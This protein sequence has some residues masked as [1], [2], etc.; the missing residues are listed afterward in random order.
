MSSGALTVTVRSGK[1]CGPMLPKGIASVRL[2]SV[3]TLHA[4]PNQLG[5]LRPNEVK[6]GGSRIIAIW[7]SP[8]G[9]KHKNDQSSLRIHLHLSATWINLGAHPPLPADIALSHVSGYR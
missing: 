7:Q 9:E 6:Y 4:Q 1:V 3:A 8:G 2:E 5:E